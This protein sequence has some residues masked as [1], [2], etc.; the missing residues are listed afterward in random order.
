[1]FI[2]YALSL[3]RRNR[4]TEQRSTSSRDGGA[5]AR[6]GEARTGRLLMLEDNRRW[7]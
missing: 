1:M 5:K 4:G 6:K 7:G 3:G 2:F